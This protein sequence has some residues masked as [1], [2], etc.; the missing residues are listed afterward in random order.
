MQL[1][2]NR[3]RRL[4][5]ALLLA[6]VVGAAVNV[7]AAENSGE[8]KISTDRQSRSQTDS[9]L[10]AD[11]TADQHDW[12]DQL[13]PEQKS[14]AFQRLKLKEQVVVFKWLNDREKKVVFEKLNEKSKIGLFSE[15]DYSDQELIFNGLEDRTKARIL[16]EMDN[17]Q[18]SK[19]MYRHPG[20]RMSVPDGDQGQSR[21]EKPRSLWK[22]G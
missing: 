9:L 21:D 4:I 3:L 17:E 5:A 14:T 20:L 11:A 12:F 18:R 13:S 10:D 6:A 8:E 7:Y 15:L 1:K 22:Q 16:T 19:W 2:A